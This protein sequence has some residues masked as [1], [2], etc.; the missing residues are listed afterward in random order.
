[1]IG[2]FIFHNARPFDYIEWLINNSELSI[3][4]TIFVVFLYPWGMPLFFMISGASAYFA[5]K[6][7]TY[8]QY[9]VE[10]VQRLLIPYVIG[11]IILTPIQGYFEVIH[12]Q[13]YSGSVLDFLSDGTILQYFIGRS[14]EVGF[15]PR[16]FG[17]WGIHLW[18]LGFLFLYSLIAIPIFRWFNSK[19]GS[20][21]TG[22]IVNIVSKRMGV[23]VFLIPLAVIQIVLNPIFPSQNDWADFLYQFMFFVYGYIL[24]SDQRLLKSLKKDWLLV[25]L[26]SLISSVLVLTSVVSGFSDSISVPQTFTD[27][28]V[29]WGVYSINSWFWIISLIIFG[30]NYLDY[31]DDWLK[32]GKQAVMP[33][34]LVHHPVIIAISFY[35]VQWDVSAV[36]KF[37]C[38]IIGSFVV[39]LGIFEYLVKRMSFLQNLFR[40]KN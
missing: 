23:I 40:G 11:S 31:E 36:V 21:F 34:Y 14:R 28:L 22:S 4:A 24:F 39:I 7:R 38:V 37:L 6:R 15:G 10:R 12:K 17:A 20:R 33:V 1:M 5:L 19:K 27:V 8:R 35:V 2:V 9:T 3:P 30:M 13:L 29:R 25:F 32:Y 18:F 26:L 16:I